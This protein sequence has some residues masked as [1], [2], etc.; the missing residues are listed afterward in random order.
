MYKICSKCKKIY[1][2]NINSCLFCSNNNLTLYL[3]NK[4]KIIAKTKVFLPSKFHQIVPYFVYLTI[5]NNNITT[6]RKS[7]K[8]FKIGETIQVEKPKTKEYIICSKFKYIIDGSVHRLLSLAKLKKKIQIDLKLFNCENKNKYEIGNMISNEFLSSILSFD[9]R[10]HLFEFI[11]NEF[12]EII[13]TKYQINKFTDK[14]SKNSTRIIVSTIDN[15]NHLQND[16]NCLFLIDGTYI[17]IKGK[18]KKLKIN[19]LT[20]D[21]LLLKKFLKS[22]KINEEQVVFEEKEIILEEIFSLK[23]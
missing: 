20:N 5:D 14:I 23:Y 11:N 17:T 6:I 22:G 7:Y 12:A 10:N 3:P 9:T 13:K 21:L 18:I 15:I 16:L 19:F 8:E 1:F 4:F 2:R